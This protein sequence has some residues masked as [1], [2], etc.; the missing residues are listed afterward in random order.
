MS[1]ASTTGDIVRELLDGVS[2]KFLGFSSIERVRDALVQLEPAISKD[3]NA[4]YSTEY[5]DA[6]AALDHF[7]SAE[8]ARLTL[9]LKGRGLGVSRWERVVRE[10]GRKERERKAEEAN[11]AKANARQAKQRGVGAKLSE[12]EAAAHPVSDGALLLSRVHTF[13]RRFVRI[14]EVQAT[15]IVLWIAFVYAFSVADHSPRLAILS[16]KKRSGK[17]RLETIVEM[18]VPRAMRSSNMSA[19]VVYRMIEETWRTLN[20]P[21]TVLLDEVDSFVFS[22]RGPMSEHTEAIRGIINSGHTP[23]GAF[24]SRMEKIGDRLVAVNYS[25]W[26]PMVYAAIG[27]LPDT[28]EDR[29]IVI[30]MKRRLKAETVEKLTRRNR[31]AVKAE[32]G[33]LA[34][35]LARWVGDNLDHLRDAT[36]ELPAGLD[37]RCEDNWDLPLAIAEL[38]GPTWKAAAQKAARD[39]SAHRND[40]ADDTLDIKLLVDIEA[41]LDAGKYEADDGIGSTSLCNALAAIEGSA[42][43][44]FGRSQKPLTANRLAMMLRPFEV[45]PSHQHKGSEYEVNALRDAVS[46]YVPKTAPETVRPSQTTGGVEENAKNQS[47]TESFGDTSKHGNSATGRGESDTVTDQNGFFGGCEEKDALEE[48]L[49]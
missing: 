24:V 23:E 46:R 28:W 18:L 42:W 7:D 14:T 37:D 4:T 48:V 47:V 34:S 16:A 11:S 1:G 15:A 40:E 6:A 39:L 41:V 27:R 17:S 8:F 36:P 2:V 22:G 9:R 21:P 49:A 13:V 44:S 25:T 32:A 29:S 31:K 33:G 20:K 35:E 5:I 12:V 3:I 38:A 19:A 26:A 45:Y 43:Q 30:A 10:R